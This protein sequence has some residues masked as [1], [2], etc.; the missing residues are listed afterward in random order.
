MARDLEGEAAEV[1]RSHGWDHA[2][3]VNAYGG[4]LRAVPE[5]PGRF[6]TV[7]DFYL[8][9]YEEGVDSYENDN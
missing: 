8:S 5:V 1:G 7:R 9:G 2:N 3:Y 4:N 6:T